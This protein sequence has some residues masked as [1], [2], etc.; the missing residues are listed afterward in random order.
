MAGVILTSIEQE[1]LIRILRIHEDRLNR[2][3]SE[4][5]IQRQV[6]L[7]VIGSILKKLGEAPEDIKS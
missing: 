1:S 5:K 7:V 2:Y 4:T 3:D 6:S